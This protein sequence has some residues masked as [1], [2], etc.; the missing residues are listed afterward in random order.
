LT[1][2]NL[3]Q[4]YLCFIKSFEIGKLLKWRCVKWAHMTHL[5]ICNTSYGIRK[6]ARSQNCNLTLDHKKSGINPTSMR[7]G[8]MQH[9]VGKLSTRVATL[10]QTSSRLEFWARSY[11]LTKLQKFQ[12]MQFWDSLLGVP[13]QKNHLNVDL[14]ERCIV[15]YMGEGGG[16]PQVQAAVNFVSLRLLMACPSTKGVP[17]LY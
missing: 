15:Y 6:K 17:T 9:A 8:G 14:T 11:S 3:P 7:A 4:I 5:D 13:R 1:F 12:R 10:L 2:F 16:F